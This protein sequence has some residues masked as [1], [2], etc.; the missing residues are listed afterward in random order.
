MAIRI[1]KVIHKGSL[2]YLCLKGE[3]VGATQK[4]E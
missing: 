2:S 3:K 4:I 1:Q